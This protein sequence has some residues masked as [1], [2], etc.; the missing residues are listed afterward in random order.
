M[1]AVRP[2]QVGTGHVE[3][4]WILFTRGILRCLRS[5]Q[6][7]R[8]FRPCKVENLLKDLALH[9]VAAQQAFE[10]SIPF[11]K[12]PR[13]GRG[14]HI[15]LLH[16]YD[17]LALLRS[18]AVSVERK[19]SRRTIAMGVM[20]DRHDGCSVSL[21]TRSFCAVVTAAGG[22]ADDH[23]HVRNAPDMSVCAR[24]GPAPPADAG[25]RSE[26]GAVRLTKAAC[27]GISCLPGDDD[28]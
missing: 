4:L 5:R 19:G 21:T 16:M 8:F 13:A 14:Y 20:A 24:Q 27:S 22:N 26:Q 12:P 17:F 11:L 9:G 25:V 2:A 28:G 15:L 23:F 10:V 3:D 6:Q 7:G 18:S 1:R